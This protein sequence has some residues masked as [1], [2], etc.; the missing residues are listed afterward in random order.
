MPQVV[1]RSV[2]V[3]YQGSD[4]DMVEYAVTFAN[5]WADDLADQDECHGACGRMAASGNCSQLC[6]QSC[7][8]DCIRAE[9]EHGDHPYGNCA[10]EGGGFEIRRRDFAFMPGEDPDLV[11]RASLQNMTFFPRIRQ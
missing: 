9:W 2:K 7:G 4:P 8:T 3:S 11:M 1:V 5:D 6:R 10:A